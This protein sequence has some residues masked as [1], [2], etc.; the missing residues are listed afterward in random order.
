MLSTEK[1]IRL[2]RA[3]YRVLMAVRGLVGKT[4]VL[5][6]RRSGITW[7][8]DLSEG[9]DLSIYLLGGFEPVT[10]RQYES[11]VR[12]GDV[13]LD[14]GANVGSHTLP[15]ARLAGAT[16]S[17]VAYEP[18][19]FAFAK[20]QRNLALNPELSKRV[21]PRQMMLVAS[22]EAK[23]P[24]EL[25]S[26]WPLESTQDL[27]GTHKGRLMQTSGAGTTTLDDSLQSLGIKRVDFVKLDVDGH[28]LD[29]LAG[30]HA[31]L[32]AHRPPIL[33]EFAP[34]LYQE[35]GIGFDALLTQLKDLGYR[36]L[37]AAGRKPLPFEL[38]FLLEHI[39]EGG[40]LNVLLVPDRPGKTDPRFT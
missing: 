19:S 33:M 7:S 37:E 38:P 6:A 27:H 3:A 36:I 34:Y 8:L 39:P 31:T 14:I 29:V 15:L 4:A 25:Y 32:T 26:S 2:A 22:P 21:I 12:P 5:E 10:L 35:N 16:G 11:L 13:V 23:L 9:I 40:S 18:T 17:V 1:K 30:A 28:E 24:G 20:L